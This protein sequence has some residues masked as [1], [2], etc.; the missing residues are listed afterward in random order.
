MPDQNALLI[1]L[2][3]SVHTYYVTKQCSKHEKIW[4]QNVP[5]KQKVMF[6]S[7]TSLQTSETCACVTG[8]TKKYFRL[9]AWDHIVGTSKLFWYIYRL[10]IYIVSTLRTH[11][12]VTWMLACACCTSCS[13]AGALAIID[14]TRCYENP[15]EKKLESVEDFPIIM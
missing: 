11:T 10:D 12:Y 6:I 5:L 2:K 9:R 13:S 8:C 14:Q 15:I 4:R 1:Q 7:Q 3:G